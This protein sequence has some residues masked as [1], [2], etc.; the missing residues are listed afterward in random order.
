MHKTMIIAAIAAAIA[1]ATRADCFDTAYVKSKANQEALAGAFAYPFYQHS[2]AYCWQASPVPRTATYVEEVSFGGAA[3]Q[4]VNTVTY[5]NT[6][7]SSYSSDQLRCSSL[8]GAKVRVTLTLSSP[9][10]LQTNWA[11]IEMSH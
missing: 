3:W 10:F 8:V 5:Q 9:G 4:H 7:S 11:I 6:T 2:S 1:T